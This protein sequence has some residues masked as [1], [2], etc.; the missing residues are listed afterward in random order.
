MNTNLK[1]MNIVWR[2]SSYLLSVRTTNK[3]PTFY[4]RICDK[5]VLFNGS[6]RMLSVIQYRINPNPSSVAP[7]LTKLF[8]SIPELID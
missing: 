7:A 4:I 5:K 3:N 6:P 8:P 1:N 2:I